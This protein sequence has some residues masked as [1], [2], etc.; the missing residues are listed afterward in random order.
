MSDV[1]VQ[2]VEAIKQSDNP[3]IVKLVSLISTAFLSNPIKVGFA[4]LLIL[5]GWQL[6][7]GQRELASEI[8]A[9][10]EY[11]DARHAATADRAHTQFAAQQTELKVSLER[12][13]DKLDE[14]TRAILS[15][16]K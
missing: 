2:T 15:R 5:F 1:S 9:G 6:T 11:I 10:Y 12:V 7:A 8:R 16:G 14:N 4:G 13:A 3:T